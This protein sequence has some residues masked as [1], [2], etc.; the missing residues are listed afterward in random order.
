M[1]VF[2]NNY[3]KIGFFLLGNNYFKKK[4]VLQNSYFK[5]HNFWNT[6]LETWG[7]EGL[8]KAAVVLSGF[9][10]NKMGEESNI[11]FSEKLKFFLIQNAT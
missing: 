5:I 1:Y 2:R 4:M 3:F 10:N 9:G 7:E 8:R 11:I 6:Y